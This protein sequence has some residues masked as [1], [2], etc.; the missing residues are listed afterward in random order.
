MFLPPPSW[1]RDPALSLSGQ[2]SPTTATPS[3]ETLSNGAAVPGHEVYYL[4]KKELELD[5]LDVYHS[6]SRGPPK[7]NRKAVRLSHFRK[8]WTTLHQVGS[9]WD[10]SQD[11]D[12][13]Y[14]GD[15]GSTDD[16]RT[17]KYAVP[18]F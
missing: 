2:R 18:S 14:K 16:G 9:Y 3:S 10:T 13:P 15:G 1:E 17:E 5:S 6:L 11:N 8:F 7:P 4:R 12:I